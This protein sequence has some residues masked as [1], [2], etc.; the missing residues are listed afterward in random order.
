MKFTGRPNTCISY[1]G[2]FHL[3]YTSFCEADLLLLFFK[4]IID[5]IEKNMKT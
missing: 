3:Y 2:H 1:V 4:S 5:D